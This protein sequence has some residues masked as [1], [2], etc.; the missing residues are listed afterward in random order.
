M[1][2]GSDPE[3][4]LSGFDELKEGEEARSLAASLLTLLYSF[5]RL[6]AASPVAA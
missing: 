6:T 5:R 4:Q 3:V 1:E 2:K